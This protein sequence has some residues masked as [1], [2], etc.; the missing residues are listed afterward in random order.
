MYLAMTAHHYSKHEVDADG[1]LLDVIK[2][3][4]MTSLHQQ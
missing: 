1:A 3:F 2:Q 4:F